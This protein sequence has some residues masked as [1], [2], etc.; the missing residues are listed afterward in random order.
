MVYD[1][2]AVGA[3]YLSAPGV[4]FPNVN[5]PPKFAKDLSRRTNAICAELGA[6]SG[7]GLLA[8]DALRLGNNG[9]RIGTIS[10]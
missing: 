1:L 8:G 9:I 4:H 10:G 7:F 6:A 5:E 3:T 2:S